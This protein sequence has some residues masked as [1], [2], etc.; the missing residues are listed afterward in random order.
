MDRVFS[1]YCCKDIQNIILDYK[2]EFEEFEEKFDKDVIIQNK[3]WEKT[4]Y[5]YMYK[6]INME[7]I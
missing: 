2:K 3:Y 5:I 7:N 1:Q 6:K 4:V